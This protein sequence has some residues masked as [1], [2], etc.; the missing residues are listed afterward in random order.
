MNLIEWSI[1]W[2]IPL[3]AIHDLKQSIGLGPE[4]GPTALNLGSEGAVQQLARMRI[5]DEGGRLFRN[6]VGAC[7]DETGRFIRYG[8]ANDSAAMNRRVKSSD[9][10]GIRPVRIEPYMVGQTLGQF[11]ARECKQKGWRYSGTQREEA[12]LR[13]LELISSMGGDAKFDNGEGEQ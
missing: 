4:T 9:L 6:N 5:A 8:L 11:V 1:K 2:G 10:I 3:E 12:Q 7:Y 13:F